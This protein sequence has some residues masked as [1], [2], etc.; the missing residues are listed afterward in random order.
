MRRWIAKRRLACVSVLALFCGSGCGE[1]PPTG[2]SRY[3][4][5]DH[6]DDVGRELPLRQGTQLSTSITMADE[7]RRSLVPPIPSR[8]GFDIDVPVDPVLRFGIGVFTFDEPGL[9]AAVEFHLFIDAGNG[10]ERVFDGVIGRARPNLWFDHEVDLKQWQGAKVR[11]VF[12]T[13]KRGEAREASGERRALALW[14]NPVL[15]SRSARSERPNV[16]LISIDCLRSDH[17]GTY[18]YS[19]DTTPTIDAFAEDGVVFETAVSTSSWTLPTHMS[20]LTGLPPSMHG[21]TKTRML[22]VSVPYLPVLLTQSGYQVDALVSVPTLSQEYGFDRGFHSYR[23]YFNPGASN[24]VDAA[25]DVLRKGDK[26]DHFLFLH[27]IDVHWPYAPPEEFRGRFGERPPDISDLLQQILNDGPPSSQTQ[28]D[29]AVNLYDGEIA[30]VDREL[31]RFLEYMKAEGLY[32][33]S[34][35]ILTADHGEAFYEHGYWKHTQ[36][37]Y[38]EMVRVPL[39]VKWPAESPTGRVANLVSQVDVFPTVLAAVG[40]DSKTAWSREL[41]GSQDR[42]EMK[43]SV[44]SEV[45]WKAL[46]TRAA[47][48]KVAF[49]NDQ[50]KY[51]ATLEGPTLEALDVEAIRAEELY[52]L[53]ADPG[54]TVDLGPSARPEAR[55][56]R[57]TSPKASSSHAE[58][59]DAIGRPGEGG[60]ASR[61]G[62]VPAALIEENMR[63]FRKDLQAYLAQ[64]R[65][66]RST[67]RGQEVVVDELLRERL[68]SLGYVDN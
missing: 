17:L 19:R 36:T 11:L 24:T 61:G 31:R 68:E 45:S 48:F 44:V 46:A 27:L 59:R 63:A 13:T 42:P 15:S 52:D 37:L 38:E 32:D 16:V 50:F 29:H 6:A 9:G 49:R 60:R 41:R 47:L 54:E 55:S 8:L 20:M 1:K 10:E 21:A 25:I 53:W 3:F 12:E 67:R 62:G 30:Y 28:I 35:I 58:A 51:I 64:A 34:L 43:R 26:Q 57:P 14:G 39:I 23:F 65:H 7:T 56:R 66:V 22:D 40:L 33:S 2:P 5:V 18:G 4:F